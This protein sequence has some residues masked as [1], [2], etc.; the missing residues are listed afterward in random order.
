LTAP[1][2]GANAVLHACFDEGA[3]YV[4]G[5]RGARIQPAAI[6]PCGGVFDFLENRT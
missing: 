1:S 4:Y 6:E 5:A 2:T 3:T